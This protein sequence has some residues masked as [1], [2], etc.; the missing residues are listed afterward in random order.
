MKIWVTKYAL[1]SGV[2]STEAKVDEA[3]KRAQIKRPGDYWAWNAFGNEFHTTEEAARARF[4]E[5]KQ[6]KLASLRKQ[7]A[8]IEALE[9]TVKESE[10]E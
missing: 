6:K 7:I 8:K 3:N 9:F 2:F 5:L 4:D 1:S 10:G